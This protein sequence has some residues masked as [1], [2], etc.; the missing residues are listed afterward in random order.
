MNILLA[1]AL[2]ALL[3]GWWYYR[4][5]R[6]EQEQHLENLVKMCR[7]RAEARSKML[8]DSHDAWG[9]LTSLQ[10]AIDVT[11]VPNKVPLTAE[12]E[13]SIELLLN[14]IDQLPTVDTDKVQDSKSAGN[15]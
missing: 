1:G 2:I 10:T 5:H 12:Q 7:Q 13:L 14:D 9:D 3:I 4:A 8:S 6:A 15:K 11:H